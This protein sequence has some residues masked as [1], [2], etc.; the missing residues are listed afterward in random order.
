M[1]GLIALTMTLVLQGGGTEV[2]GPTRYQQELGPHVTVRAVHTIASEGVTH[3]FHFAIERSSASVNPGAVVGWRWFV[4]RDAP[5]PD[6]SMRRMWA[7]AE[8]CPAIYGLLDWL[9]GVDIPSIRTGVS[10]PPG[11]LERVGDEPTPR[12]AMHAPAHTIEGRGRSP[13]FDFPW[14]SITSNGGYVAQ[15]GEAVR[16]HLE[17][18][19]REERPLF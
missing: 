15:W 1:S 8:D 7:A 14:V 13:D 16:E 9:D 19:W 3:V 2:A 17:P 6:G 5:A 12:R 4:M 11:A 18:C 10:Q